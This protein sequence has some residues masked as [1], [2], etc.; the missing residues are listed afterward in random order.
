MIVEA[1]RHINDTHVFVEE[2]C[3]RYMMAQDSLDGDMAIYYFQTL[4]ERVTV[5]RIDY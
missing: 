4:R 3:W 5:M 1:I 2:Y